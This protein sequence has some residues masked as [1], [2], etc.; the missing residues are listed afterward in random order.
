MNSVLVGIIAQYA[1]FLERADESEMPL[2]MV[3]RQQEDLAFRLQQLSTLERSEFVQILS[4]LA[5]D[6]SN[7]EDR[8]IL[9]RLPDETGIRV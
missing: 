6:V 3:V 5:H 1:L 7:D 8:E 9:L 2:E 4:A